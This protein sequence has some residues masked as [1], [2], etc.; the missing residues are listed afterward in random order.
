M[1]V[2]DSPYHI[3]S[4]IVWTSGDVNALSDQLNALAGV[5]CPAGDKG[6]C[7][8]VLEADNEPDLLAQLDVIRTIP[9]V[10]NTQLVYHA[11]DEDKADTAH[12]E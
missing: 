2:V 5:E 3:A 11:V 6:K 8:A 10:M 1:A 4:V 12:E 9:Q 7:I